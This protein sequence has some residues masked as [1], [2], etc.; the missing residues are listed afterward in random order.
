[1]TKAP[2]LV[3]RGKASFHGS[4]N[5]REF[6]KVRQLELAGEEDAVVS[7]PVW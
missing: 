2:E 3:N 4:D 6:P 5:I 7:L 1:M